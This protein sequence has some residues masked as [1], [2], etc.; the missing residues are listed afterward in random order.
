MDFAITQNG[1][2]I[3]DT[4]NLDINLVFDDDERYQQAFCRIQ[5]VFS[6]WRN[7]IGADL[8]EIISNPLNTDTLKLCEQKIISSLTQD[9]IYSENE[10]Y[11]EQKIVENYLEIKIYL[12][13]KDRINC[14]ILNVKIDLVYGI[15]IKIGSGN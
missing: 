9:D 12:R 3:V 15:N 13:N 8:E 10:I 1:E 2:L 4:D 5:S 6:D 11:I 7:E 14:R